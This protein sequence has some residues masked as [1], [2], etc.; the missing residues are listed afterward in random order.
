VLF[1]GAGIFLMIVTTVRRY[2]RMLDALG[3]YRDTELAL[4]AD[5]R[6]TRNG[7]MLV[8]ISDLHL[9]DG[10]TGPILNPGTFDIFVERLR[11]MAMRAS[12]RADGRYRPLERLD[13]VFLGDTLDI[14]RSTHW[15]DAGTRPWGDMQSSVVSDTVSTIVSDILLKNQDGLANLRA[16]T[17]ES[18]LRL[19]PVTQS[20]EPV[21]HAEGVPVAVHAHYMVG[22]HDWPLH[23]RGGRYDAIRQ[24]VAQQM[25]LANSDGQPF[26]HDPHES[27]ELLTALRRHRVLARHGDV[28]D[29]INFSET[30]DAASLGDAIVVELVNRFLAEAALNWSEELPKAVVAGLFEVYH[31]RPMLLIPIWIDGLLERSGVQAEL[32]K[33]MKRTWD[34]LADEFLQLPIVREQDSYSPLQLVDGLA[35]ALKFSKRLS[36]G[37][38]AKVASWLHEVRGSTSESY[39][40][41]ALTE[42]DFRNRRARN[43]VYGH[44]HIA[45]SV[46]LDA[47]YA[48][49][50]VLNQ[51]YFNAGTW[52][53]VY[54]QTQWS[55]GEQEFIPCETMTYLAFYQADE[56]SGRPFETWSGTLAA[57]LTEQSSHR[58]DVGRMTHAAEQPISAPKVPLRAPH[59][60]RALSP[61]RVA[62]SQ[63]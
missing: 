35:H 19:P 58:V 52:R 4:P 46:P 57:D 30:R 43:I 7:L 18:G 56:R 33:Q 40:Q 6:V 29:P 38:A 8:I 25:G 1:L 9:T 44:T 21:F 11:E 54:R 23:L 51:M 48:D 62:P 60:A 31:I 37:W 53:R 16:V 17:E 10:T 63:R 2:L 36:I 24:K 22:N 61:G 39:Y 13:L 55:P 15:L 59:F 41:H 45:E 27:D 47:S 42:Q 50:Y 32:R 5:F 34:R 49:G 26:P 20:G 3:S 12:W 28:F 14:T